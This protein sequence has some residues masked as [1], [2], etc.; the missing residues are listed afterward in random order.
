LKYLLKILLT[1]NFSDESFTAEGWLRTRA[2]QTGLR[3]VE[4]TNHKNLACLPG[5]NWGKSSWLFL[6]GETVIPEKWK[7]VFQ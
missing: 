2:I 3:L 1:S 6:C 5:F 7:P 4:R